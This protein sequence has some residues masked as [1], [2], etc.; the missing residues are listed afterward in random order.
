MLVALLMSSEGLAFVSRAR[1]IRLVA[2]GCQCGARGSLTLLW[3]DEPLTN[4]CTT[5]LHPNNALTLLPLL[6]FGNTTASP[7]LSCGAEIT[8]KYLH[9]PQTPSSC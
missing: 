6:C 4:S 9:H 2:Q 1:A 7:A 8:D 5:E 3:L